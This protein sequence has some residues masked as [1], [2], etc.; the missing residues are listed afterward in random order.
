MSSGRTLH[1]I[2]RLD[3]VG[4]AERIVAELVR[5][6]ADHDVLCYGGGD[7]FYDLGDSTLFRAPGAGKGY[8]VCLSATPKV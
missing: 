2:K 7:S 1:I 5:T 6:Q 4:G 8:M 3:V